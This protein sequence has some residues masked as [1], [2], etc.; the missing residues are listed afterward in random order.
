MFTAAQE[1]GRLFSKT[2]LPERFDM[3][4]IG[5]P[6]KQ[7][8]V[9]GQNFPM[10]KGH[11][12]PDTTQ[13][14]GQWRIEVSPKKAAADDYFLHFIQAGD[15]GLSSMDKSELVRKGKRVGVRITGKD[16]VWEALFDTEGSAGG[17][18][19]IREGAKIIADRELAR[20]V[21]PQKGL[22]GTE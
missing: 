12:T 1:R 11:A 5:G 15:I 20:N 4:K 8:W 6:G 18:I 9:D 21:Q 19:S 22:F 7:F 2:L 17:H 3:V 16:R 10:P 14:L 13:L